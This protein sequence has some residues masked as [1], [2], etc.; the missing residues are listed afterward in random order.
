[1]HDSVFKVA[2]SEVY[3]CSKGILDIDLFFIRAKERTKDAIAESMFFL[4]LIE[5][6]AKRMRAGAEQE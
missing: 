5:Q 3:L 1:M 2:V 4:W 6:N